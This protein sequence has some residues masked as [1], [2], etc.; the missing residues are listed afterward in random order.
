MMT[1][2]ESEIIRLLKENNLI[3][4]DCQRMLKELTDIET[5]QKRNEES[6]YRN[7]L[8]NFVNGKFKKFFRL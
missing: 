8:A 7:V 6:F 3:L 2:Y 1:G 4:K 5:I